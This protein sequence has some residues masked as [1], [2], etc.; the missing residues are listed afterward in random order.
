MRLR[1]HPP[2]NCLPTGDHP[3]V[4]DPMGLA[5]TG[6][7]SPAQIDLVNVSFEMSLDYM[8]A[9]LFVRP[10]GRS[11]STEAASR[12]VWQATLQVGGAN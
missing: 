10:T 3:S 6:T 11:C 1:D 7:N 12:Q 9:P 8:N 4:T 2:I 5:A